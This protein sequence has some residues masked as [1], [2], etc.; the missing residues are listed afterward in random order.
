MFHFLTLSV[1]STFTPFR[2]KISLLK[3]CTLPTG[4]RLAALPFVNSS[5]AA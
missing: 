1:R 2:I 3:S 5:N 4:A